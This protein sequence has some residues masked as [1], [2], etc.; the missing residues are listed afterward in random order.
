MDTRVAIIGSGFGMYCLLPA[1]NSVHGC[2]VMSICGKNSERMQRYCEN[3]GLHRYSDWKEMLKK[4]K[5]QAIAIAVIPSYQYEIARYALENGIAVFADK[6]LTTSYQTS[7]ELSNIAKKKG[8]PNVVDFIFPEI[9]EWQTAKKSIES[10]EIGKI[11][12]INIE[13]KFLSYDLKNSVKSWKT[14]VNQGGGA[15]SFYF[16]HV[17]YYMEFFIGRIKSLQ[18]VCSSSEKS[19]NKGETGINMDILFENGCV[20]KANM[21]IGYQ[22]NQKHSIEFHGEKGTMILQNNSNDF[23]D[24]FELV[25]NAHNGTQKLNSKKV[26]DSSNEE[27][28][29][30]RIKVIKPIAQRFINWCNTGVA[31]RPDFQDG[32]RVQELVEMARLS[33]SKNK[34]I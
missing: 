26:L 30:P 12:G 25:I 16:S 15:L 18:C 3:L 28:E 5:P 2:K 6:P 4:E 24:N 11:F 31:A 23:V 34:L 8:L 7:F 33:D 29:D 20:G 14:D 1:F 13:W 9:S 17:F 21:D 10:G 32:L 22:G 19:L 27:L